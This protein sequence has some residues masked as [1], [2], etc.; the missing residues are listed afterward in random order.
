VCRRADVACV[1]SVDGG[2]LTDVRR[3]TDLRDVPGLHRQDG[4]VR[5]LRLGGPAGVRWRCQAVLDIPQ[6][7]RAG[8]DCSDGD[9]SAWNRGATGRDLVC[10]S[11]R[12]V[13]QGGRK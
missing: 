6:R 2:G 3:A 13:K 7:Q 11:R 4:Q 1:R 5:A 12:P 8:H 9:G 10:G